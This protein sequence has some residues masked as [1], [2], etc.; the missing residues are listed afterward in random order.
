MSRIPAPDENIRWENWND[1]IK[2]VRFLYTK[3]VDA[4][5]DECRNYL[6]QAKNALDGVPD[7]HPDKSSLM[8]S[9]NN[10]L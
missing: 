7:A 9:I 6:R 2:Y 1:T 4:E 8:R 5:G 10:I 3:G